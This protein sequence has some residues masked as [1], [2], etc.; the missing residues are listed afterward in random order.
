MA[1]LHHRL[2]AFR[3]RRVRIDQNGAVNGCFMLKTLR[4]GRFDTAR[5]TDGWFSEYK[6]ECVRRRRV[7]KSEDGRGNA[8]SAL[9]AAAAQFKVLA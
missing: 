1:A 4:F 3:S 7:N 8:A 2:L 9:N 6:V 5:R